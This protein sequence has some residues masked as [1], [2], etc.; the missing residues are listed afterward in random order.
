MV[1]RGEV[2]GGEILVEAEER[3]HLHQVP[4]LRVTGIARWQRSRLQ[5]AASQGSDGGQQGRRYLVVT[6]GNNTHGCDEVRLGV[7]HIHVVVNKLN[8]VFG[9]VATTF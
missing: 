6:G 9:E 8:A 1:Q 2:A 5:V 7:V 3:K 4:D